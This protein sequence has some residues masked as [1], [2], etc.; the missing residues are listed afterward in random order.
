MIDSGPPLSD[1]R[2][3]EIE[4][5]ELGRPMQIGCHVG[6]GT[7]LNVRNPQPG[8]VY[9]YERSKPADV[10]R[11]MNEGWEL[12]TSE[13]PEG[14]GAQLPAHVQAALGTARAYQDVVL[15]RAPEE[16]VAARQQENSEQARLSREGIDRDFEDR[17]RRLQAALGQRGGARPVYSRHPDHGYFL[18][19][20]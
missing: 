9:W 11:K 18:E 8:Y 12:V 2:P 16:I 20:V 10:L 19:E 13:H 1:T 15:M 5:D 6:S 7:A 4:R 14:W 3:L 17:G